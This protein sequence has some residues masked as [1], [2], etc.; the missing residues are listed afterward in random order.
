MIMAA[1]V[2]VNPQRWRPISASCGQ[3]ASIGSG[4]WESRG[5]YNL[6]RRDW[7]RL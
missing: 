3:F 1:G 2:M 7:G 6:P 4:V 5:S